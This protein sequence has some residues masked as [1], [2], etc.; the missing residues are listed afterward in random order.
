VSLGPGSRVGVYEVVS[1]LGAG[2]MGEVFRARDLRLK[3]DVALKVMAGSELGDAERRQRFEREAQVLAALNHP[4]VAQVFG[5]ESCDGLPVIAME[6]VEGRTLADMLRGGA[7]PVDEAL[8]IAGQLCDGLE[9]AHDRGIV[10]RDLKPANITIRADG[11][12]KILDFG[13]ARGGPDQA[14]DA[15][16]TTALGDR[17]A[18]GIVMGTAPYMSP[19]QARGLPVD[20]RTDIWAF[21]CVLYEMLTG[22]RAFPGA[23]TTDVLVAVIQHG[24]DWSRLPRSLSPRIVE[25]L[26]RCLAKDIKDRRRDIGDAAYEIERART[27]GDTTRVASIAPVAGKR[28]WIPAAFAAGAVAGAS[29]LALAMLRSSAPEPRAI[30]RASI[31][32]PPDTTLAPSRGSAL[33]LSPDGRRLAFA[34]RS[35]T[36]V[37]LYLRA[38]DRFES[39]PITGTTDAVNPFFSPDGRWLA[40]FAQ[41]KLKK[42]LVDGGGAPLSLFDAPNARGHAWSS[43]DTIYVTPA[44]NQPI[45]RVPAAG[46]AGAVTT[47]R[48]EGELS[49]R[50]PTVLANGSTLLYTIWNDT[51]W[52]PARI[53]AE[54]IGTGERSEVVRAGGGYGRFIRDGDSGRG[55]LVFARAEGLL[56][57]PF[58]ESTLTL[59]GPPVPVVDGLITNLSGGAQF[60]VSSSGALAYVS[61]TLAEVVRELKWVRLDGTVEP[62]VAINGMGRFWML[63]PDGT[64]IA[65]NNTAGPSRDVWIED[66]VRK[67][68]T[69]LTTQ[70]GNFVALWSPDSQWILTSR[71]IPSANLYRRAA[72]GSD[73]EDR[74]TASGNSQSP[75]GVSPDGNWLL[76]V[77]RHPVSGLD[78]WLLPVPP[79]PSANIVSRP[80]STA[81]RLFLQTKFSESNAVFSPDGKWVAYQSNESGRFETYVCSFPACDR[82]SQV[83]TTGG[84]WPIWSPKPGELYFRSADGKLMAAAVRAGADLQVEKPREL[85]SVAPY[86]DMMSMAPDGKRFLAMQLSAPESATEIQFVFNFLDELR[87]RVR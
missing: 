27:G 26:E 78:L 61:G 82:K 36:G 77:E 76:Y 38:I 16:A 37:Q 65:R 2:G 49:H 83:S 84:M 75:T 85:F 72:D 32:L 70:D 68:S 3:R 18:E 67:T 81:P 24:P 1:R 60:D 41:G 42:V 44:N 63:S 8:A 22:S 48:L 19:E 11:R 69:R 9:A 6:Y 45:F 79:A 53:V 7:L 29:I 23:T 10:H 64:R 87:Q 43:D 17:T 58:D 74:L 47:K 5:V 66:L 4:N 73:R 71:G 20:R 21:G 56:A 28:W 52:E 80:P 54:R 39:V 14:S 31:A 55:F 51:G 59:T 35:K 40:F 50:W 33:T 46:G 25:L 34:G 13:I 12:A 15:G 57:A 62:A 86:E 30:V